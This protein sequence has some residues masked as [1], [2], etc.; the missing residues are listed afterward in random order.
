MN[1]SQG[2]E[3]LDSYCCELLLW[4]IGFLLDSKLFRLCKEVSYSSTYRCLLYH[5]ACCSYC[6]KYPRIS[7]SWYMATS[8]WVLIHSICIVLGGKKDFSILSYWGCITS[9]IILKFNTVSLARF[10]IGTGVCICLSKRLPFLC[11]CMTAALKIVLFCY[12]ACLSPED[13]STT[14]LFLSAPKTFMIGMTIVS[15]CLHC[16]SMDVFPF[17]NDWLLV[18]DTQLRLF[19]RLQK[20]FVSWH[21]WMLTST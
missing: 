14:G 15:G 3:L 11:T 17:K 20:T 18:G 21:I 2:C 7:R 12:T 6:K 4:A 16:L 10:L 5:A 1:F 8:L 9:Y 13:N 19:N